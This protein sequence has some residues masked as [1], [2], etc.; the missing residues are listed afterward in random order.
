MISVLVCMC[1]GMCVC[2]YDIFMRI[3]TLWLLIISTIFMRII[4]F[5]I[6]TLTIV[7]V[8]LSLSLYTSFYLSSHSLF[9]KYNNY[10]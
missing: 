4:S 1:K 9:N 2:E 10:Y 5:F 7:F 6:L 3:M 8:F